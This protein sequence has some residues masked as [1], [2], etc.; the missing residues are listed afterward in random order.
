[1]RLCHSPFA[2]QKSIAWE[3]PMSIWHCTTLELHTSVQRNHYQEGSPFLPLV[4][5][6]TALTSTLGITLLVFYTVLGE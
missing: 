3:R 6:H 5:E 4:I 2:H 1:M